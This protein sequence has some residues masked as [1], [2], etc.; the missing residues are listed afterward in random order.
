[1][2]TITSSKSYCIDTLPMQTLT[3][4]HR[5]TATKHGFIQTHSTSAGTHCQNTTGEATPTQLCLEPKLP[6][7]FE[8]PHPVSIPV[9]LLVDLAPCCQPN[10]QLRAHCVCWPCVYGN[11]NLFQGRSSPAWGAV[12]LRG[13]SLYK[14]EEVKVSIFSK[15]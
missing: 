4:G 7:K 5:G 3:Q 2:A 12:S 8:S 9:A 11:E 1:M 10:P 15:V 14:Q 6:L 13:G